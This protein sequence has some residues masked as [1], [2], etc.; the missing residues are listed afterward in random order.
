LYF[1]RV[2]ELTVA[3]SDEHKDEAVLLGGPEPLP[4]LNTA[5]Q[6]QDNRTAHV[7]A[8]NEDGWVEAT[9]LARVHP[10]GARAGI[11]MRVLVTLECP[12]GD[13][14]VPGEHELDE[15][16]DE[17]DLCAPQACAAGTGRA[18]LLG[19]QEWLS[20]LLVLLHALCAR[21]RAAAPRGN[22]HRSSNN[23]GPSQQPAGSQGQAIV[24]ATHRAA[25]SG[26]PRRRRL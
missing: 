18:G 17:S 8:H 14:S 5:R 24:S 2:R 6:Q 7:S 16:E 25:A 10:I 12:L 23:N 3:D 21:R 20:A 1:L 26:R 15:G 22:R 11:M 4:G 19:A 13:E 9:G